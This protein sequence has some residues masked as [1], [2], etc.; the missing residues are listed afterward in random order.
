MRM[1]FDFQPNL[2][3]CKSNNNPASCSSEGKKSLSGIRFYVRLF[4]WFQCQF[5]RERYTW[6]RNCQRSNEMKLTNEKKIVSIEVCG[7][8]SNFLQ[9]IT[10]EWATKTAPKH[11][12]QS[13]CVVVLVFVCFH[14]MGKRNWTWFRVICYGWWISSMKW[15]SKTIQAFFL[16]MSIHLL[17]GR[18]NEK[19]QHNSNP[20]VIHSRR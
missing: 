14:W 15:H 1:L 17:T 10:R 16:S 3:S 8:I 18:Q 20:S 2:M 9:E 13:L 19:S 12:N 5:K 7:N 11:R 6:D 4:I